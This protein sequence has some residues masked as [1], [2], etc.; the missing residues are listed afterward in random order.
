M[1]ETLGLAHFFSQADAVSR[2]VLGLLA[3]MSVASW[4]LIG[5]KVWQNRIIHRRCRAFLA[6]FRNLGQLSEAEALVQAAA[7]VEPFARLLADGLA[8][9]RHLRSADGKPAFEL[10]ST[11]DFIAAALQRRIADESRQLEHG[12][13][14]LATIGSSSPFVGLFGTVWGIYHALIAIGVSGQDTLDKVAGPV[15]EAL[16]MTACGL[17]VAIPAVLAYNDCV[18]V[19]RNLIGELESFAHDVFGLLATGK[20]LE[21]HLPKAET[22]D[23]GAGED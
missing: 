12:L 16:I 3:V 11:D 22:A 20:R 8:T 2:F 6:Q 17:A 18:Q 10:T 13:T 15:G 5:L 7:P 9:C 23:R 19:N 1:P 4:Y 14:M 21:R